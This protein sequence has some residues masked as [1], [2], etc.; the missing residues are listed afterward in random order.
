MESLLFLIP[1]LACPLA[2][3]AIGAVGWL[4]AK[5]SRRPND[6]EQRPAGSSPE[7]SVASRGVAAEGA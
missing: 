7:R 1:L 5:A 4:W 6:A 3:A 2:M